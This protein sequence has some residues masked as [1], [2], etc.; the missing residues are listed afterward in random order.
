MKDAAPLPRVLL[1][2]CGGASGITAIDLL[3]EIRDRCVLIGA[4]TD[5]NSW[6]ERVVDEFV[7]LPPIHSD[8]F[9]NALKSAIIEKRVTAWVPLHS[10]ELDVAVGMSIWLADHGVAWPAI[11]SERAQVL[12]DKH[13]LY[14]ALSNAGLDVAEYAIHASHDEL[15]WPKYVVKPR[16]GAGSRGVVTV[17]VDTPPDSRPRLDDGFI[18]QR[19]IDGQELSLDGFISNAGIVVGP[20][21][22]RRVTVRHGMATVSDSVTTDPK[23]LALFARVVEVTGARGPLN[24]QVLVSGSRLFVSD[25]NPRFP[26]GGMALS[27]ARGLNLPVLTVLDLIGLPIDSTIVL[28]DAPL[29]HYRVLGDVVVSREGE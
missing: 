19:Y 27:A 9:V 22:R 26:A 12:H 23:T 24:V 15:P 28:A 6:G 2:S 7:I 18:A 4:D 17:D 29:R 5:S 14:A 10:G 1:T 13:L 25:V 16:V 21:A 20:S 3:E 11:S 8:D